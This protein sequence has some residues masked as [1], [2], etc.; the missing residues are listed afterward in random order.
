VFYGLPFWASQ[1][2]L[3]S[4]GL[5]YVVMPVCTPTDCECY[6]LVFTTY[7]SLLRSKAL[8]LKAW[9]GFLISERSLQRKHEDYIEYIIIY[10]F[11]LVAIYYVFCFETRLGSN[12]CKALTGHSTTEN[13][14]HNRIT[15]ASQHTAVLKLNIFGRITHRLLVIKSKVLT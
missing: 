4:A 11:T 2:W 1:L 15:S 13:F 3:C 7:R 14:A 6:R 8:A 10:H 12:F 5:M 9:A